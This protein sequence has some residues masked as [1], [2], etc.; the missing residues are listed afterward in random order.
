MIKR[1]EVFPIGHFYKTHGVGGEL[2][3][4][5]T[6]DVFEQGESPYWVI[7]M[8]GILVPFFPVSCRMRSSSSALV[9]L[10]GI[11]TEEKARAMVGREVYYPSR[12]KPEYDEEDDDY[13]VLIGFEVIDRNEGSLG[14][15]D[16][17]DDSTINVLLVISNGERELLIPLAGEYITGI[18]GKKQRINVSL[19]EELIHLQ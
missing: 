19:P 18:D 3:F 10:D 17:V 1:D 13:R 8:D 12:F 15:V 16:D 9:C 11:D 5:F 14:R 6:T 7:D 2:S 4:S